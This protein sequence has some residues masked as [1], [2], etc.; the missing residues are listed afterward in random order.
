MFNMLGYKMVMFSVL[1]K[2]HVH[3]LNSYIDGKL[4][5]SQSLYTKY[6]ERGISIR[7]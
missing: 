1:K 4:K 3:E 7:G 2:E 6:R 5:H